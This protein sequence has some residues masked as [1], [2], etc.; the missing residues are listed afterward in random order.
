MAESTSESH[1]I[2]RISLGEL[3]L[4]VRVTD[5]S[6]L[7]CIYRVSVDAA[8]AVLPNDLFEPVSVRGDALV[9]VTALQYDEASIGAYSEFGV[10]VMVHRSGSTPSRMRMLMSLANV[11]DAGWYVVNLAVSTGFAC[12]AGRELWGY[13]GYVTQVDTE[14]DRDEVR[15]ILNEELVLEHRSRFGITVPGRPFVYFSELEGRLLRTVVPV[16]HSQSMGGARSVRIQLTGD[17]PTADMI[18]QLGLD[19]RRPMFA[20]RADHVKLTLP[21]GVPIGSVPVRIS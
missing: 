6:S 15:V 19:R 5:G 17:G 18:R 7:A 16:E 10:M 9:Q 11:E 2:E 8:R 1:P 13:P 4:P 14:F 12:A 20:A 21:L 3:E